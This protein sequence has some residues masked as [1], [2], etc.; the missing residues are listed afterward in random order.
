[1]RSRHAGKKISIK[2]PDEEGFVDVTIVRAVKELGEWQ[3]VVETDDGT[4]YEIAA[5]FITWKKLPKKR[6]TKKA[7]VTRFPSKLKVVK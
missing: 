6:R 1:M 2:S 3:Y 7:A 4:Q 5:G